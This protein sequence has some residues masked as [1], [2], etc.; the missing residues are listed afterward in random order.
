MIEIFPN[1]YIGNQDDYELNAELLQGWMVVHACKDPYHRMALGYSGR[2]APKDHPEY[3]IARRGNQLCL[4]LV[5]A[6]NPAFIPKVIIDVALEFID[7]G[8]R[9]GNKVL[10]HCNQGESRSTSIGLLYLTAYT[11]TLPAG[12]FQ[13]AEQAYA[14]LCPSYRPGAGMRGFVASNWE[15]YRRR[16]R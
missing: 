4:N 7:E 3:Y 11:D 15:Q 10:V 8:L 13:D 5:D 12:S 14:K 9:G 2:G 16:Q 6:P 1:L